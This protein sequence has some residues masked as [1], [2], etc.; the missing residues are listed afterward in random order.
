MGFPVIAYDQLHAHFLFQGR[1]HAADARLRVAEVVRR[2]REAAGFGNAQ[3]GMVFLVHHMMLLCGM[4]RFSRAAAMVSRR[5]DADG[6]SVRA[7]PASWEDRRM[8]EAPQ[9][10]S[11]V[12][13]R[14]TAAS[15]KARVKAV[16]LLFTRGTGIAAALA[17][18]PRRVRYR[19]GF[20]FALEVT[21]AAG[22]VAL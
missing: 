22:R 9:Q 21:C 13:V 14:T 1:Y 3:Q 6:L 4:Q 15:G 8:G 7:S 11:I 10:L 2:L 20:N 19:F 18:P 5:D 17:R 16:K 12:V